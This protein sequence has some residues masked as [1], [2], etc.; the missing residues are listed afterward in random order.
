MKQTAISG[1]HLTYQVMIIKFTILNST[2]VAK[3]MAESGPIIKVVYICANLL[4]L[5]RD[6]SQAEK[7]ITIVKN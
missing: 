5:A 2:T 3:T 1:Y 4:P 6:L 7:K